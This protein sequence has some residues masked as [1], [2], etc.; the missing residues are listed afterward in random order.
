M[1]KVRPRLWSW[2]EISI[3][4]WRARRR[5]ANDG[6]S[7]ARASKWAVVLGHEVTGALL[8]GHLFLSHPVGV[9]NAPND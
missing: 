1:T 9:T 7:A 4:S 3:H 6:E 2:H 8:R 5:K